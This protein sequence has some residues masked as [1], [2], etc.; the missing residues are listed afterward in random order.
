MANGSKPA[1]SPEK[2]LSCGKA[3]RLETAVHLLPDGV[4]EIIF[5]VFFY[6]LVERYMTGPIKKQQVLFPHDCQLS[7]QVNLGEQ[8]VSLGNKTA[9]RRSVSTF[10]V[11]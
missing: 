3:V 10:L 9:L 8:R 11:F 6:F 1:N 7:A 4:K 5:P 2:Q